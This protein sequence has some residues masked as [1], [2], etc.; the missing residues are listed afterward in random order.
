MKLQAA[1]NQSVNPFYGLLGAYRIQG[2]RFGTNR[3]V[4]LFFKAFKINSITSN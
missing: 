1:I 2:N 3:H 4:V